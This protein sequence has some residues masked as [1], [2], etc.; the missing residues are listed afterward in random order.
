MQEV[1]EQILQTDLQVV[2]LQE[3]R[4]KG[5]GQMKKD[6]Y[7]LYYSCKE[8]QTGHLGTGF[9][10]K[11]EI[12]KKVIGVETINKRICKI[13]LT[14][15]YNITLINIHAPMEEKGDDVKEQFYAELQQVQEKVPKHDLLIILGDCNAKI[16]R[17]NAYQKVTSKHTLHGKQMEMESLCVNMPPLMIWL[18]RVLSSNTKNTYTHT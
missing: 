9:I 2:V 4:W 14:G 3:I 13:R 5:Q 8:D 10:V 18:W 1:A 6:K 16:G 7:N 11:K 17:E 15:K 12:T